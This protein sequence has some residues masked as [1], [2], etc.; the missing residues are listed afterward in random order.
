MRSR[1]P[2]KHSL[3]LT[4]VGVLLLTLLLNLHAEESRIRNPYG[5]TEDEIEG[6]LVRSPQFRDFAEFFSDLLLNT[7]VDRKAALAVY[8]PIRRLNM[9]QRVM[10]SE[11]GSPYR[12]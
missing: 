5:L 4:A 10:P 11:L 2:R 12:R 6:L 7:E 9:H 3:Q 8:Q 1:P